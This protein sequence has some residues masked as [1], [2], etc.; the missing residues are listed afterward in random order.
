MTVPV[1]AT[2]LSLAVAGG[3]LL[4]VLHARGIRVPFPAGIG[5]AL[6]AL[7]GLTVLVVAVWQESRP[8]AINAALLLFVIAFISGIFNLLFRLR[9]ESPP[10]FMIVLHGGIAIIAL[11]VLWLGILH[12]G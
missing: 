4:A 6:L 7:A 3:F 12:A 5:H 8:A 10:G 1:A 9:R 2:L 11:A